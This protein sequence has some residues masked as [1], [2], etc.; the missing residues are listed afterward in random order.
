MY[1]PGLPEDHQGTN[2]PANTPPGEEI[3]NEMDD[4]EPDDSAEAPDDD[5]SRTFIAFEDDEFASTVY[6]QVQGNEEAIRNLQKLLLSSGVSD[7]MY[8]GRTLYMGDM[9]TICREVDWHEYAPGTLKVLT[10]EDILTLKTQKLT[11]FITPPNGSS[12]T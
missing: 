11:I 2:D 4:I 7:H 8:F 9:L 5:E 3:P 10:A 12:S 1:D 6:V